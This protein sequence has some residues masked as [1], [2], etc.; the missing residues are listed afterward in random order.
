VSGNN[1]VSRQARDT[2]SSSS[3]GSTVGSLW[4]VERR[5]ERINGATSWARVRLLDGG[6]SQRLESLHVRL[7]DARRQCDLGHQ[8]KD[9]SEARDWGPSANGQALPTRLC[10]NRCAEQL[11][12][13]NQS[14]GVVVLCPLREKARQQGGESRLFWALPCCAAAEEHLDRCDWA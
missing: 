8:V 9:T 12:R 4:R 14:I 3:E 7:W 6:E 11:A 2:V 10:T 5:R 13:L 1:L